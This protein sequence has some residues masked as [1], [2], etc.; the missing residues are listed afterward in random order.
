[1]KNVKYIILL[2]GILM[3]IQSCEDQEKIRFPEFIDAANV[4]IQVDPDYSSLDASDIANA[5]LMYSVFSENINIESVVIS[6]SYYNFLN[7]TSYDS[8]ELVQ[9]TQSDFDANNGAIRDKEFTSE[10]LAQK[11]GLTGGASD[12]GGGD[13]FDFTNLTTLTNGMVFPD[14]IL[15]ETDYETVNVTPNIINSSATTSFT[16]GFNAFVACPVPA[17]FALGDYL[18]EQTSGPDDPFF[19]NPTRWAPEIVTLTQVSA[20]ERS[21]NGTYFTFEN[22]AFNFLLICENIL[23]GTTA[24]GLG[25]GGPGI[26]WVG[27][28]PPGSYD[29]DDDSVIIIKVLDNIDGGCGLP[30]AEPMTLRLTKI[31]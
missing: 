16:V 2:A 10:F 23:V 11:F 1:M 31:D 21:F 17:G 7:D 4:R 25:C 27:D 5:K 20:I 29:E 8:Q 18:L 6:A 26:N 9:Y 22:I 13:R 28:T 3:T 30:A 12:L 24:S 19:G 14:T 15:S